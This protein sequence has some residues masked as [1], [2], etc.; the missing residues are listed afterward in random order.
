MRDVSKKKYH[1]IGKVTN[2]YWNTYHKFGIHVPKT[3]DEE[4]KIDKETGTEF[5]R[6]QIEKEMTNVQFKLQER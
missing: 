6:I 5:W 4:L 1:I 2:K 3:V